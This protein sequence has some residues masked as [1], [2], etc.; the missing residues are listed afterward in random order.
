MLACLVSDV[1]TTCE[2]PGDETFYEYKSVV[3][4]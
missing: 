3:V 2:D 4:G 1:S